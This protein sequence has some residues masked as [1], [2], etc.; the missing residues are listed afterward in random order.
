MTRPQLARARQLLCSLQNH[1]RDTLVGAR[2]R[3][4]KHFARI[5]AVTAAD[6]IYHIDKISE[7]AILD[8]FARHWPRT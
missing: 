8:W 4:A 1:I 3:Q 7:A 5:A 6:T 2:A